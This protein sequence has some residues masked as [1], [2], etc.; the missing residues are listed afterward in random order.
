MPRKI[1]KQHHK[2]ELRTFNAELEEKRILCESD[3]YS[4]ALLINPHRVFGAIHKRVLRWLA[5]GNHNKLLLMPRDHQKSFCMAVYVAWQ[6]ARDPTSTFLYLS[7]T[8]TLAEKQLY[9][10]KGML[11][12]E[13][14]KLLWPDMLADDPGKRDRWT[15]S[16]INVDHPMRRERGIRDATIAVGGM[17][18]T[19]AGLHPKFIVLDDIVVPENA[20]T[21]EGRDQVRSIYSYLASIE[22]SDGYQFVT[23]TRY[24]PDDIYKDL[25]EM[26]EEVYNEFGDMVGTRLVY[27]TIIEVVE[28]GGQF[29]WPKQKADDG[30]DYGFDAQ[31]LAT[32]KAKYLHLDQFY[33]QYYNNPNI[34]SG[35]S[36]KADR[37]KYYEPKFLRQEYG[38]MLYKQKRLNLYASMDFAYSKDKR[39]DY[40]SIVVIGMDED[41]EI[42]IL[43]IDRFRTT[44]INEYVEKL[45]AMQAKWNFKRMA[46]EV[47]GAQTVL[48]DIIKNRMWENGAMITIDE[49]R[50]T[51]HDGTKEERMEAALKPLYEN[52]KIWHFRGGY[53]SLLE[54][55]LQVQYPPHDDIKDA[56][57]VACSKVTPPAKSGWKMNDA[58]NTRLTTHPTFGGVMRR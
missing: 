55:E 40:T 11:E 7:A 15:N 14:F 42:Y 29:L 51:R 9:L 31:L 38:K 35:S 34:G 45:V 47:T 53:C 25:L 48:V 39:A 21:K 20:Q 36:I 19:I 8:A 6:I 58:V 43:D 49:V 10:I 33:A 37:F 5:D 3:I 50:P 13:N 27:D 24:H 4:F 56:L 22:S 57:A 18:K 32:K 30:K 28:K 2:K 16:E 26:Q 46:A 41:R 12:S 17:T 44:D 54:E 23:G 52:T 1:A